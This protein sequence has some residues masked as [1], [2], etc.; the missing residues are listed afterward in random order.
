MKTTMPSWSRKLQH[1]V[2]YKKLLDVKLKK[3][4]IWLDIQ[5]YNAENQLP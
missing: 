3:K 5:N 2:M 1:F 4:N